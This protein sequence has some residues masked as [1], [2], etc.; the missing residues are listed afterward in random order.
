MCNPWSGSG[1]FYK[2]PEYLRDHLARREILYLAQIVDPIHTS[3]M[4]QAWLS[5]EFL[6]IPPDG[7]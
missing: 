1:E 2:L 7:L 3:W 5:A 4:S 6:E